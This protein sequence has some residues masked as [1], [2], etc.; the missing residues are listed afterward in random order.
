MGPLQRTQ[1]SFKTTKCMFW[2]CQ[3][4]TGLLLCV[5]R[6]YFNDEVRAAGFSAAMEDQIGQSTSLT[7]PAGSLQDVPIFGQPVV[8]PGSTVDVVL[9][10][11]SLDVGDHLK[12]FLAADP[13][14]EGLVTFGSFDPLS[15]PMTEELVA[16]TW[17]WVLDPGSGERI[18]F[19]SAQEEEEEAAPEF[20]PLSRRP[21]AKG[22]GP[23]TGGDAGPKGAQKKQR[24]TVATFSASLEELSRSLPQLLEEVRTLSK[25]TSAMEEQLSGG[26]RPYKGGYAPGGHTCDWR[27]YASSSTSFSSRGAQGRVKLQQEL[28]QHR[29]TFF[30][31]VLCAMARR[32]QPARIS[33]ASPQELATRGVT[34]TQYVERY[35]G[36]GR[37]RDIGNIMWQVALVL[38]RLQNENIAGAKDA[39]A[40]LAVCPEQTALDNGRMDVALLLSLAEDPPS[41]LFIN[42]TLAT[43]SRVALLRH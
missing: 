37:C 13:L 39:I 1:T 32:M 30:N 38:D 26:G 10:D 41:G 11:V 29:G 16:A 7:L 2:R 34:A 14:A 6:G 17:R 36:Y 43:H 23:G 4:E 24:P 15:V 27:P 21:E 33:E 3:H 18:A 25:R 40:L 35:G 31:A 28:A 20:A 42:R 5:P 8:Q 12:H 19:Y 22:A 9:V